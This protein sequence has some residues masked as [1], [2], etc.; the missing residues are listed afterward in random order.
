MPNRG[1]K[2]IPVGFNP[3]GFF[4]FCFCRPLLLGQITAT[5]NIRQLYFLARGSL[6]FIYLLLDSSV[7][8][9]IC[10]QGNGI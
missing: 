4:E 7:K 5:D 3:R 10:K 2:M 1:K 6:L 8:Y 9:A